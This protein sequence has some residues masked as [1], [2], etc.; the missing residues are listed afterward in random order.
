MPLTFNEKTDKWVADYTD[1]FGKRHRHGFDTKKE[2]KAELVRK[3]AEIQ[4]RS[5]RPDAQRMKFSTAAEEYMLDC[6]R[7]VRHGEMDETTRRGYEGNLRRY[8]LGQVRFNDRRFPD[9]SGKLFGYPLGNLALADITGAE[10]VEFRAQVRDVG[11]GQRTTDAIVQTVRSVLNYAVQ[12][13][14]I[15]ANVANIRKARASV[16]R[17]KV[18][19]PPEKSAIAALITSA[20]KRS[21]RDRL[22]ITFAAFTGLR[23]S[24]Q[25]ALQWRHLDLEK[26][27]VRVE[28]R[29]SGIGQMGPPKSQAGFRTIPISTRLATDLLNWRSVS[30]LN[31]ADDLVF[32]SHRGTPISHANMVKFLFDAAWL[33]AQ[34]EW[35]GAEPLERCNWHALRHFAIS[36]WIEKD[37]PLK[38]VQRWAGHA[39]ASMTLDVYGHLFNSANHAQAMDDITDD[40]LAVKE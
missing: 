14:Y 2:A 31:R 25:R 17:R 6:K 39:T 24:E 38:Q 28:R 35:E 4:A 11:V 19:R 27:E 29:V 20:G 21:D 3:E 18:V 40:I 8:A 22:F 13:N 16:E 26:R 12:K 10:I 15:A 5:F 9:Q 7:R 33:A 32:P 37:V 36:C 30:P 1:Q 34:A 23:T